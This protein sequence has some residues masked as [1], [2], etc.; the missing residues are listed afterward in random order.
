MFAV[1][2]AGGWGGNCHGGGTR[3]GR[4]AAPFTG[5]L[6]RLP[7]IAVRI[8]HAGDVDVGGLF[9]EEQSRP[10]ETDIRLAISGNICR[11]TGY[12]NIVKAVRLAAQTIKQRET[13][14]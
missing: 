9:V 3:T 12:V 11:C 10:N 4:L 1:R 2:G 8:L 13:K 14:A 7:W 5:S 6:F